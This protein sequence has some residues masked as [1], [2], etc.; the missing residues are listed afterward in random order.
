[1]KKQPLKGGVAS[2]LALLGSK[3]TAA[4]EGG[5]MHQLAV[6]L[7][8]TVF[9]NRDEAS[10]TTQDFVE[11]TE[12]VRQKGVQQPILVRPSK[13][14]GRYELIAGE[15]RLRASRLVKRTTIPAIVKHVSDDEALALQ[16][17]ENIHRANWTMLEEARKLQ[18]AMD[19]KRKAGV[20]AAMEAVAADFGKSIAWVSERLQLL[21]LSA[22]A[23]ALMKDAVTADIT[24]LTKVSQAGKLDPEAGVALAKQVR[25][26]V[27]KRE[28]AV[29]GYERIKRNAKGAKAKVGGA[30]KSKSRVAGNAVWRYAQALVKTAA[31]KDRPSPGEL[32]RRVR[33]T[34]AETEPRAH[35]A[36]AESLKQAH[37]LGRRLRKGGLAQAR[38][39]KGALVE[40][41]DSPAASKVPACRDLLLAAFVVGV[42][43]Q[44]FEFETIVIS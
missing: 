41:L 13:T 1:M 33:E 26:T 7:I 39:A 38:V 31:P 42:T 3:V 24:V 4:K 8:D 14:S 12:S 11:F 15:R 20:A 19:T 29:A 28:T 10:Y 40:A 34:I 30:G 25:T 16:R 18:A 44:P 6:D 27:N 2:S 9:P 22:P 5:A 37:S 43:G 35:K 17:L 36:L 32:R 23:A 21:K